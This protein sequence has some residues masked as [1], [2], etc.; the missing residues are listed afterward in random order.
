[1]L[2]I[3][4]KN[5]PDVENKLKLLKTILLLS[6]SR[7]FNYGQHEPHNFISPSCG[8]LQCMTQRIV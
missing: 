2:R 1:M 6:I 8:K 7:N 5:I 4:S 3:S